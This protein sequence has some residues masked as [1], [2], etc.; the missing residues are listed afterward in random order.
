[1]PPPTAER[2]RVADASIERFAVY[3]N[4]ELAGLLSQ[5][6]RGHDARLSDLLAQ[7]RAELER[8]GRHQRKTG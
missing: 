1:M 2:G 6:E 8:R 7:I 4:E 5:L 3:S